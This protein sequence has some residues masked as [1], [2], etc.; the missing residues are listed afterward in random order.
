MAA[1][2]GRPIGAS[3]IRAEAELLVATGP[4]PDRSAGDRKTG[5]TGHPVMAPQFRG[6][7]SMDRELAQVAGTELLSAGGGAVAAA[8]AVRA[9]AHARDDS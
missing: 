5:S 7:L 2:I 1:D 9:M 8:T 3:Q 4:S 6:Q